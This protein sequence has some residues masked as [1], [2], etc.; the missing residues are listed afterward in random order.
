MFPALCLKAKVLK[1]NSCFN[2]N[3]NTAVSFIILPLR[4]AFFLI[5]DLTQSRNGL[6]QTSSQPPF[7]RFVLIQ[8][9]I[10]EFF[11]IHNCCLTNFEIDFHYGCEAPV[12][13]PSH[14]EARVLD[15]HCSP[16]PPHCGGELPWKWR[17][18]NA[19]A[20]CARPGTR[21]ARRDRLVWPSG[22]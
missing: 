20:P 21:T 2:P 17:F 5:L 7:E 6:Y 19:G 10:W 22:R 15:A 4:C 16:K 18:I 1:F 13:L 3:A 12:V 14:S 11:H 8:I 9:L